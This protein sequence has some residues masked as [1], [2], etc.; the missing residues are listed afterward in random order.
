MLAST[1]G[2][3]ARQA[4][5][6]QQERACT[7]QCHSACAGVLIGMRLSSSSALIRWQR[8]GG[9]LTPRRPSRQLRAAEGVDIM[10]VDCVGLD[11]LRKRYSQTQSTLIM[12]T[13]LLVAAAPQVIARARTGLASWRWYW[14][15]KEV[16]AGKPM[17]LVPIDLL[18]QHIDL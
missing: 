4:S 12:S 13:D 8:C 11:I 5:P 1:R 16:F 15:W 3:A 14:V 18:K 10:I 9:C 2:R 6:A 17:L 7:S